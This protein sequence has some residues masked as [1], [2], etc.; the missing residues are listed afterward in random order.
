MEADDIK[1]ILQTAGS[2]EIDEI[3]VELRM[4]E[5]HIKGT[6]RGLRIRIAENAVGEAPED[7]RMVVLQERGEHAGEANDA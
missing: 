7:L 5:W 6:L 4:D 3:D 1:S 2:V